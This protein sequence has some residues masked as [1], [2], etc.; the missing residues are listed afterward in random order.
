MDKIRKLIGCLIV[1]ILV[2]FGVGRFGNLF[3]PLDTDIAI[4]AINTFHEMPDNTFEVIGYGSSHIWR[5]LN[6]IE[7]YNQYGIGAFNYGCNWQNINTTLLFLEDSLTTQK[8][9]VVLIETYHV[10][11][12]KKDMN[13]DGEIYYTTAIP[14]SSAKQEYLRQCFGDDIER[15]LSYYVPLCA[16]HDN[17]ENITS[18][19]F[20]NTYS[21]EFFKTMGFV[22]INKVTAVSIPDYVSM[23]QQEL[24]EDSIDVL[25]KIVE[26]CQNENI[27]IVFYTAPYQGGYA[28]SD[29]MKEYAE[30]NDCVYF[31][32]F[33]Y[34][35]EIGFDGNTDFNDEGHLNTNGAN[36]VADFLGQ[37]LVD[38]YELTDFRSE[39]GNIWE[40]A[41]Q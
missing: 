18:R 20:D 23:P 5:G 29:A 24:S 2:I 6:P 9:K 31:N 21:Y 25:N 36:K 15:Y 28:F 10:N 16:F 27:D 17:W 1:I 12:L 22:P 26:A 34:R 38:S 14:E 40:H 35:D 30:A 37:Y 13:I 33:E 39:E 32:L 3:R 8:P 7:M 4:S 19:S 41:Q 11:D